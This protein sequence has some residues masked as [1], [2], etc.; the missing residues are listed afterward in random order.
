MKSV[1]A[2]LVEQNQPVIVDE[3][4][5]KDLL[6]PGQ[7]L[8]EVSETGFCSTQLREIRGLNGPDRYLPHLFGHEGVGIVLE[9]GGNSDRLHVGDQVILHWRPSEG[10]TA[11]GYRYTWGSRFVNS[12]P[13]ATFAQYVVLSE[14]RLTTLETI[15]EIEAKSTIGCSISTGWG[16]ANRE[17]S[18]SQAN[19][20]L[21]LGLG[22]TGL[23]AFLG[24]NKGLNLSIAVVEPSSQ[25]RE[26]LRGRVDLAL[27][28]IS[29]LPRLAKFDAVI[30]C[31]GRYDNWSGGLSLLKDG[32]TFVKSGM[33][34]KES[35]F[36]VAAN[37]LLRGLTVRGSNGGSF[38][39][40][41]D[42]AELVSHIERHSADY[43]LFPVQRFGLSRINEAVDFLT[44]EGAFKAVLNPW[45]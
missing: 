7:V 43:A 37:E 34:S 19:E 9:I 40:R 31:S 21:I 18:L 10:L 38:S 14:S 32:G 45:E 39:P 4:E 11:P 23:A 29:E 5:I 25:K 20:V 36:V 24:F 33:S 17:L 16:I 13:I 30:D 8:V 26:L 12:G 27:D 35:V 22:P 3:L 1:A 6:L 28:D 2:I 42:L 41:D 44:K 15:P